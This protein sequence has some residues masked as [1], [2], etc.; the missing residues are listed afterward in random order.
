MFFGDERQNSTNAMKNALEGHVSGKNSESRSRTM[1][2]AMGFLRRTFKTLMLATGSGWMFSA[3]PV[4]GQTQGS[5][6]G[7]F[8]NGT[9]GGTV[10]GGRVVRSNRREDSSVR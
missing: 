6:P 5:V 7:L 3:W 2:D 8:S 10:G 9:R 1:L 4:P